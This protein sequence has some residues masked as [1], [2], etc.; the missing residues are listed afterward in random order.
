MKKYS[1]ILLTCLNFIAF[2]QQ[3][4]VSYQDLGFTKK[5]RK[6]ETFSYSMEDKMVTDKSSDSYD[7]DEQ[8]N[9]LHHEY[10]VYGKYASST[11]ENSM[12]ENGLL[13]KREILVKNQPNFNATLTFQYDKKKNLIQK[14]YQSAQYK[15]VF[16]FSYDKQ[17]QLSEIKGIYAKNHSV[18]KFYYKNGRLVK[19]VEEYFSKDTVQSKT[20]KLY[21]NKK[22]VIEYYSNDAF[23][24][25]YLE[26]EKEH[27]M[28]QMNYPEPIQN[29]NGIGTEIQYDELTVAQLK[30]GLM[31]E[32]NQPYRKIEVK[33]ILKQNDSNDWIAK[34]GIDT[35]YNQYTYYVFRKI[36]YADG[37][38]SGSTDF[39][40]FT[41]NELKSKLND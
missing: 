32:R 30:E 28:L 25:A 36:T 4:E 33:E 13:V 7:F 19:S 6:V 39:D 41:V 24:K 8:G 17:N 3:P 12:Y 40:I 22:P 34:A 1:T 16:H 23:L 21:I 37:S 38:V 15:N 11:S 10:H 35:R 14:T 27:I 18:E 29:V 9:I 20:I 26:D 5:I 2:A 31:N